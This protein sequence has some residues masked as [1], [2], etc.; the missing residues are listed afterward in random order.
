MSWGIIVNR[1]VTGNMP[2]IELMIR[3]ISLFLG[4]EDGHDGWLPEVRI[5]M[6]VLYLVN[7]EWRRE[8]RLNDR[9]HEFDDEQQKRRDGTEGKTCRQGKVSHPGTTTIIE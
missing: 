7:M 1:Y 4:R 9:S 8:A 3:R 5:E 6:G 2:G